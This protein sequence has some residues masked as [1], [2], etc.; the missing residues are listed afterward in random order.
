MDVAKLEGWSGD[1]NELVR[2]AGEI[3]AARGL[4]DAASEPTVRL[5]R[6]YAQRGIVSRAERQGK[7]AI[8]GYRQ[9]L[10]LVAA[11]VLIDDRW[12]KA[13]AVDDRA[14]SSRTRRSRRSCLPRIR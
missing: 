10:E 11:R 3:L 8:Y 6:D 12:Y 14:T 1:A 13:L 4:A 7:E 5:V 2:L 9:L